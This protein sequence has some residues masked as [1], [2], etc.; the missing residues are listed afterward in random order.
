M[1]PFSKIHKQTAKNT[2][3]R[4]QATQKKNEIETT[5]ESQQKKRKIKSRYHQQ[6]QQQQQLL[7][8]NRFATVNSQE[9]L[10]NAVNENE[11]NIIE[12]NAKRVLG[13]EIM[14]K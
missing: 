1:L 12:V 5:H 14:P 4:S 9:Y 13:M 7:G 8:I 3:S 2:Q 6:Q 10:K 11:Q